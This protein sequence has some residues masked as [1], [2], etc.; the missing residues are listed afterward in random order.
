MIAQRTLRQVGFSALGVSEAEH[1][2]A[3]L[4]AVA[5]SRAALVL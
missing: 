2:L 4:Y 1:G 3:G 5:F